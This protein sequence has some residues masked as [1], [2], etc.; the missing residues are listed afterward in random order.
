MQVKFWTVITLP[1]ALSTPAF[2][3]NTYG[4]IT[5]VVTDP[6]GS[7]IAG[8]KVTV[9]ETETGQTRATMT[10]SVGNYDFPS[11]LPGT[12]SVQ[13]ENS[14][15]QTEVRRGIVLQIQ[16]V[17]RID[18]KLT[19]GTTS[20]TIEVSGGA[21]L[22][23]TE[24]A[25]LGTV[26]ETQKIVDLPLNGRD[27]LQLVALSPNVSASFNVNGG[28]ANGAAT[29]R[30]GGQRAN[31]SF[32]VSGSRKEYSYYTLDGLT[33]TEPNFNAYIFLPSVDD[34]QE[35]K[36]QTGVYSA[37]FGREVGQVTASTKQ[38]TNS[39]HGALFEFLRNDDLDALPYAFTSNAPPKAP[40]HQ[41]DY[42]ATIGG[43][44]LKN[45]LFFMSNYEG[46]RQRQTLTQVYTTPTQAMRDGD[47]SSILPGIQIH[48]PV[49]K[50]PCPG[51]LL[52]NCGAPYSTLDPISQALLA[53]EPLPNV[54]GAGNVNNYLGILPNS[55]YKDQINQRVD[56]VESQNSSWFGRYSWGHDRETEPSLY[57]NGNDLQNHADQ[58]MLANTRILSP[59]LVNDARIGLDWFH[60]Q[61]Y[62]QTT[63]VPQFN[64]NTPSGLIDGLG[65]QL[66]GGWGPL[67]NGIPQVGIAN[68]SSFG[69]PTEGP[70][71]M[72]DVLIQFNDS[73]SWVK[74]NHSFK[75]GADLLRTRFDTMGNAF[76]RGSFS[77]GNT[78]TG[79]AMADYDMGILGSPLKSVTENVA[80][81]R[82]LG[83]GYYAADTWKVKPNLTIDAGLRYEFIPPWGYRNDTESNWYIPCIS[84]QANAAANGC[85]APTLVRIGTGNF[86]QNL[87]YSQ[88]APNVPIAR[89]G[90]LGPNLVR[91]DYTNFAPRVGVAYNYGN[92]VFRAG[93]G[94]FFAQDI[95][96]AYYDQTRNLAG[97]INPAANPT[98]GSPNITWENPYLLNGANPCGTVAPVACISSPGPLAEQYNQS[99]PYMEQWTASLQR[100][101][102]KSTVLEV[103]YLGSEGHHL[104]RYHYLNQPVPGTTPTTQREPWSQFG[105]F[106]YVDGDADSSYEAGT[107]ELNHRLS[108]GLTL[109]SAFT[110]GKSID[111]GSDIRIETNDVAPQN[112]ACI[113][114][115]TALSQFNQTYRWVTSAVYALPF[116]KGQKFMNQGGIADE[117]LG[118][119]NLT[120]IL[121][122][123]SGFPESVSTGVNQS[124]GG[125]DRPNAVPGQSVPLS[126]PTTKEWFNIEAFSENPIAQFGDVGRNVVIGPGI[127]TWDF[128][129]L[130]DFHLTE[131][132][133]VEFRFECFNCSNHP[134]FGDPNLSLTAN[135][136]NSA[137]GQA[138]PGTGAFGTITSTRAGIFMRELQFALKL[139]F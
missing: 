14:G 26:V 96:A 43:P 92:W 109:L 127:F 45:R 138:V 51:N 113:K 13:V 23:D 55:F 74:G 12:Y 117:I 111:D 107:V 82:A 52:A 30:L 36:V 100:Q 17:A 70:Y 72:R 137:T 86:Y 73:V 76:A 114:C 57:L 81:M 31:E 139:Y 58:A 89:N 104:Q 54:P 134:N 28:S 6:S 129:A 32:S 95:G 110:W 9:T 8:A 25:T 84:Y 125:S 56:F 119:W 68:Y 85:P 90:V 128:S 24:N 48:N 123:G 105:E 116:G 87:P 11:L 49:T 136:I 5:G 65:L 62:Y 39:F 7:S 71:D 79:Y 131:Q 60:N 61:N 91:S 59:A 77:A 1:L 38:G 126:N 103:D 42:G 16:Q 64:V 4:V 44:I 67:D 106:Q 15:F 10:N 41:N 122:F 3:Q 20:Q 37:E 132:R 130:K 69:T 33:D 22:V 2:A 40:F 50:V 101:L 47:F 120:S 53:Y 108:H 99:T 102:G 88:F 93:G 83:Q 133:Y 27:F 78:Y 97:R 112:D 115:E 94:V 34:L 46:F 18:F 124:G 118:G 121:T 29:T 75:F 35:F 63:D 19:L 66:G 135:A 80:Q 21:P 98:T